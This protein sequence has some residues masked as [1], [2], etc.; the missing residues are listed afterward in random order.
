MWVCS[1]FGFCVRVSALELH[2]SGVGLFTRL[3]FSEGFFFFF[4]DFL[5]VWGD[6]DIGGP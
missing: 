6:H 1:S 5:G 3:C 4:F 2:W